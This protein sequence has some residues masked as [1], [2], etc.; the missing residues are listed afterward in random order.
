[1][2]KR[3]D[4]KKNS[5]K[6]EKHNS[7]SKKNK[8][9]KN[10]YFRILYAVIT[11]F[12]RALI[13]ITKIITSNLITLINHKKK[14]KDYDNKVFSYRCLFITTLIVIIS[15]L[16]VYTEKSIIYVYPLLTCVVPFITLAKGI[17]VDEK[18]QYDD[19]ALYNKILKINI[20]LF[21]SI[22]VLLKENVWFISF[23]MILIFI[24]PFIL[25]NIKK[26]EI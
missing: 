13:S 26:E 17:N 12:I 16:F 7:K 5:Y 8:K 11:Y 10:F 22:Y 9:I 18:N 6:D 15:T 2:S 25:G 14:Y 20:V 24:I 1:M 23:Y 21:L 3:Y 4:K 19:L